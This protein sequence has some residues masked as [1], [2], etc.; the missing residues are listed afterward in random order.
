MKDKNGEH[1]FG[2]TGQLILGGLFLVVWAADSFFLHKTTCLAQY[3]PLLLRLVVSLALFSLAVW[4]V[5]SAHFIVDHEHRLDGVVTT[6]AFHFVRHPLYLATMLVY[7]GLAFSTLSLISFVML[8][9]IFFFY[10]YIAG[11]EEMAL[12][13]KFGGEYRDYQT[14]T[15]RWIPRPG[16]R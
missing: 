6:G 2:D 9:G 3:I 15:G 13:A 7:C 10:N 16:N 4:L 8:V 1:P 12:L 11:F 5:R 14:R